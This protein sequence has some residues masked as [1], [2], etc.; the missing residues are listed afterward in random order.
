MIDLTSIIEEI[1]RQIDAERF[2]RLLNYHPDKIQISPPTL[3]CFCPV[4]HELAFRS[5][6]INLKNNTYKCT[7]KHCRGFEGGKL[8]ELWSLHRGLEPI[9]AALELAET[10]KLEI[11]VNTLRQIGSTYAEKA[12]EDLQS[13]DLDEARSS[14]DQALS[15]DPRNLS[16]RLLSAQIWEEAGSPERAQNERTAV[17]DAHLT[18]GDLS[19]ARAL[20]DPLLAQGDSLPYLERF[21]EMMR[22]EGN[23]EPLAEALVRLANFH[24]NAGHL[25]EGVTALDE[26]RH[27]QPGAPRHLERLAEIHTQAGRQDE[28]REILDRLI[29]LYAAGGET[30]PLLAALERRSALDPQ[31]L[32]IRERIAQTLAREGCQDAGRAEWLK[33]VQAN[34][35]Q[36]RHGEAERI[37]NRMIELEPRD[38]GLIERQAELLTQMGESEQAVAVYRRL[39]VLASEIGQAGRIGQYFEQARG[40]A[41]HDLGLRRD[42]AEWKLASG[43]LDG[44]LNDLFTLADLCLETAETKDGMAILNRIAELAPADLDKRLRIGRCLERN[45]LEEEA[46]AS[47]CQLARDF[48]SQRQ[49]DAAQAICEEARRM[50]PWDPLTLE[51]RIET[52]LALKQ[53]SEAIEACREVART[54]AATGESSG[55]EAA[56]LRAIKIDRSETQA[57]IDLAQLYEAW[58]R[59]HEATQLW[60]EIALFHR[61][62]EEHGRASEAVREALR[63]EPENPEAR[64]M[65]AEALEA[66]GQALEA[67][68]IW[69]QLAQEMIEQNPSDPEALRLLKHAL[70]LSPRRRSLVERVARMSLKVE[71]AETA[72]PYFQRWFESFDTEPD[73]AEATETYRFAVE[74]YPGETDWRR[75]LAGLLLEAGKHEEAAHHFEDLLARFKAR[76]ESERLIYSILEQVALLKPERLDLRLELAHAMAGQGR[77]REAAQTFRELGDQYLADGDVDGAIELFGNAL[78]NWPDHEE[79]IACTAEL[80]EESGQ[81][82]EAI[83]HYERLAALRRQQ[84]DGSRNIPILEKLLAYDPTRLKLRVELAELYEADGDIDQAVEQRFTLAQAYAQQGAEA[85]Q[86]TT[87]CL[88]IRSLAPEFIPAR[89]LL[90]KSWLGTDHSKEAM[91]ELD[92]LGDLALASGEL[93][94]AEN[95][96]KRVQDLDPEDIG[97]NERLGKLYEA[98][99]R[100][101]EAAEAFQ[102]VLGLYEKLS[103]TARAIGV[104]QKLKQLK[105]NDL[106][107]RGK[108]ARML[109]DQGGERREAAEEWQGL[110]AMALRCGETETAQAAL[111]E[112]GPYFKQNWPWRTQISQMLAEAGLK[113]RAISEWKL[114]ASDAL[115]AREFSIAREAVGEGL[116]LDPEQPEMLQLRVEANRRL[117]NYEAA[118]QDLRELAERAFAEDQLDQAEGFLRQA[119]ELQPRADEIQEMLAEIQAMG[120]HVEEACATYRHLAEMDRQNGKLDSA[121]QRARQ[122]VK[123]KDADPDFKDYLATILIEAGKTRE[124][125]DI[126]RAMAED[127]VSRED[128]DAAISR[129]IRILEFLPGDI[130]ILRRLADLTY[131]T[132][133][134]LEAMGAV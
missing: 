91:E 109:L 8:V 127:C 6:I 65:L 121:I 24:L 129:Y 13:G 27:L 82:D 105:P 67:L 15:F 59:G 52:H 93:D 84:T 120:D 115:E 34:Q 98:R 26:A 37:L 77:T 85:N 16:L 18:A 100:F 73:L 9:E 119:L 66:M 103:E 97:S 111:E 3:K 55:A 60:I 89:E 101:D 72:K 29:E 110:I 83:R 99:N 22:R 21:V 20:L 117:S 87:L 30:N 132:G 4:H 134:M 118:A 33:I 11:D 74:A 38:V 45:G 116:R 80:L 125:V 50:R 49:I 47:Y 58:R 12:H 107:M 35:D 19:S 53:K 86:V 94:R 71:D 54:L 44:G 78:E 92:H 46:L 28:L 64:I 48:L 133:G 124:A 62:N 96:F 57:K 102:R 81:T 23:R 113:L 69:E 95:Y 122:L 7:M 88:K 106:E 40:I 32:S 79:L 123:L 76:G 43:N 75:H 63:L 39:A 2:A 104:L 10:L 114:L 128:I 126:W 61:A 25:D 108:L 5:L 31:D 41:P 56:L 70:D 36:G 17:L 131:E 42:Q 90:V 1:N 130:E 14:I 51:L 112:A 68:A